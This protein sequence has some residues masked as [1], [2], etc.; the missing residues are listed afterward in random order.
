MAFGEFELD[1]RVV[2]AEVDQAG[3]EVPTAS[4]RTASRRAGGVVD[5]ADMPTVAGTSNPFRSSG[6]TDAEFAG[7]VSR[8]KVTLPPERGPIPRRTSM[9]DGS[10]LGHV[11]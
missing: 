5:A 2:D 7:V 8:E 9:A 10:L 3:E 6:G 4:M 1:D 11:G